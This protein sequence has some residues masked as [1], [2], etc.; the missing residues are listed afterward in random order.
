MNEHDEHRFGQSVQRVLEAS[1]QRLPYRVVVRLEKSRQAALSRMPGEQRQV[2][3]VAEPF[4]N[5]AEVG[6]S[7]DGSAALASGPESDLPRS[8]RVVFSVIPI[9]A[10][11]AGLVLIS[12][13]VDSD[14]AAEI[15]DVDVAVLVDD[16]PISAYTDRG[17]G[18]FLKNTHRP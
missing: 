2:E 10:V 16:L 14:R 1:A 8:W 6:L 7:P 5:A 17:F 9:L 4:R 15:A 11:V 13:W 18:V 12:D 3:H